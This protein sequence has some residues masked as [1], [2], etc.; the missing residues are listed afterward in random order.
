MSV[1]DARHLGNIKGHVACLQ[2]I[3]NKGASP[4]AAP[5]LLQVQHKGYASS[6]KAWN[7]GSATGLLVS[8]GI[9]TGMVSPPD[10]SCC[11]ANLAM[12]PS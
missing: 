7:W 3:R 2:A 8:N 11:V 10:H 1:K 6:N 5:F 12:L 9:A 4:V